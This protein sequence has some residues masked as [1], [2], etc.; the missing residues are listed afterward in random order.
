MQ[1]LS[2][3]EHIDEISLIQV[4]AVVVSRE[5]RFITEKMTLP[6]LSAGIGGTCFLA[7]IPVQGTWCFLRS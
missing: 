3:S 2:D 7:P 4:V 5:V 6:L 1:V